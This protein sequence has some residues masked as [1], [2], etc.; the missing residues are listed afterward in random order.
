MMWYQAPRLTEQV[1][2]CSQETNIATADLNCLAEH[3]LATSHSVT[4]KL[5]LK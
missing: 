4:C 2:N 1:S 5:A 3:S